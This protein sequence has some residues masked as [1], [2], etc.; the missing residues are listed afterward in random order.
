MTLSIKLG[1]PPAESF[2]T[3]F[4]DFDPEVI[5]SLARAHAAN[6]NPNDA[7][8]WSKELLTR[9]DKTEGDSAQNWRQNRRIYALI[10]VAEGILDRL[11]AGSRD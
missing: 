2:A 3:A 6:G 4:N 1:K 5:R 11:P 8:A 7:L 9:A 10:G